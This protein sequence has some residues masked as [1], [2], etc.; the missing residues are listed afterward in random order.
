MFSDEVKTIGYMLGKFTCNIYPL[1][2]LAMLIPVL[3][4]VL[5]ADTVGSG[6][7]LIR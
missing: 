6:R 7:A 4:L 3:L 1:P 2:V 5:S